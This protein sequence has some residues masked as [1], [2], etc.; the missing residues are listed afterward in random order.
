MITVK[1]GNRRKNAR[2][3]I[4]RKTKTNESGL[5]DGGKIQEAERRRP[6]MR[7]VATSDI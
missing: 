5:D 6:T 3:K 4:K 7:R 2:K 1:N